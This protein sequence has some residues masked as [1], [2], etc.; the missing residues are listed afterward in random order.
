MFP[1]GRGATQ[2]DADNG[3]Y[4]VAEPVATGLFRPVANNC[5]HAT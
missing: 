4:W 1:N 2:K 3:N 5:F